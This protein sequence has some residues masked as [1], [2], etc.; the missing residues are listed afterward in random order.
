MSRAA[1]GIGRFAQLT[2][3][4]VRALR[5]Y[6]EQGLLRPDGVDEWSRYRRYSVAQLDRGSWIARLRAVDMSLEDVGHFL[7]AADHSESEAVLARHRDRL[8]DRAAAT[9]GALRSIE[10]MM[11]ELVTSDQR[12]HQLTAMVVKTLRDQPVLR[13]RRATRPENCDVSADIDS[14]FRV[15][16]LQGL[17]QAGPPYFS[18]GEP[19]EDGLRQIESGIPVGPAGVTDAEIEAAVLAG[20]DVASVLYRGRYDGIGAAYRRL[21]QSIEG[22]GLL[23]TGD[24][25][26]VYLTSPNAT[27]DPEDYL[28]EV[29]WPVAG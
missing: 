2:G 19:D 25:R 20:G 4:S 7:D 5:L 28:T 18:A 6:D 12:P 15:V 26:D 24:P 3:L 27:P 16:N 8:A 11:A 17:T 9:A 14:V 13:I 23:P 1:L 21:W 10:L 22:A 29:L